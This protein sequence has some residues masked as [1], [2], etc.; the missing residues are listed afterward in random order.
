MTDLP[1]FLKQGERA[2]LFPIL[3]DTSREK[4]IA[5]IYLSLLP[6]VPALAEAILATTGLRVGKRT[7]IEAFTE[8]VLKEANDANHR[9]DGLLIVSTGKTTWSALVEAKIGKAKLDETQVQ[10][11][12][13]M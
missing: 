3:A 6:Q 8:V 11:Y 4:R 10:K 13:E 5:S 12:V 9:P 2:R 1:E 7:R